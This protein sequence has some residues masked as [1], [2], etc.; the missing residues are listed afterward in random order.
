MS[1]KKEEMYFKAVDKGETIYKEWLSEKRDKDGYDLIVFANFKKDFIKEKLKN[2]EVDDIINIQDFVL[3][4]AKEKEIGKYFHNTKGV[5]YGAAYKHND[6]K[7]EYKHEEYWMNG[8]R[9]LDEKEIK[10]II[11]DSNFNE[12]AE[13]IING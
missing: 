7:M 1:K 6:G 3:D 12:K 2:K 13:T 9:I 4:L 10:K 8:K 5:A 11:H